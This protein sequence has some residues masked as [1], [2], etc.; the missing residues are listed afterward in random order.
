MS[1]RRPRGDDSGRR[2]ERL[3]RQAEAER[4][5]RRRAML[6]GSPRDSLIGIL[7]I[8]FPTAAILLLALLVILPLNTTQEFSFLLS[9]ESA[10]RAG[11]RMRMTEASYRGET[12]R[13]EP[14]LVTAQSG[15]QKSSAVPVVM[16]TGLAAEIRQAEGPAT[17]TAPSGEFLIDE[18]R[19]VVNGPVTAR[20]AS[21][22]SLDGDRIEVDINAKRVT[23]AEPVSGTLPMGRFQSER[24][25][26]DIEGREVN[27]EGRVRLRI[28]P[29]RTTG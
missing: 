12:V 22:F 27:L 13:G 14:F 9:K 25:A 20:S 26:A 7:K 8:A 6:P 5:E 24:F 15:V 3:S 10:A 28:T 18:N 11:E 17:V 2:A 29:N 4:L 19:I 23:S 21:G 16:L 1:D